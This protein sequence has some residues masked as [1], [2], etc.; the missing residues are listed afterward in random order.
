MIKINKIRV[1]KGC[2]A[3][4]ICRLF[5]LILLSLEKG[6]KNGTEMNAKRLVLVLELA[7]PC[8]LHVPSFIL[9]PSP[10]LPS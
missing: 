8:T 3:V 7:A 9:I 5:C 6:K 4:C 10:N 1:K 2:S